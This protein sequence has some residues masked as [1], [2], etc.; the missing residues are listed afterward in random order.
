MIAWIRRL[1]GGHERPDL[2]ASEAALERSRTARKAAEARQPS[3]D[4]AV[5]PLRRARQE[6][7]LAERI[8]EAF[9]GATS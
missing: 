6:N 3:V 5:A 1:L 2:R 9:R 8:A 4:A 7:H